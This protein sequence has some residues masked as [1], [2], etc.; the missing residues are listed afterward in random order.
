MKSRFSSLKATAKINPLNHRVVIMIFAITLAT[1]TICRGQ[2]N[3]STKPVKEAT[4]IKNPGINT[5]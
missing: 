4:E 2:V 3:T 1:T 5:Q